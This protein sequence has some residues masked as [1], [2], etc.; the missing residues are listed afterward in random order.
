MN[1]I[2]STLKYDACI[3]CGICAAVCQ[4]ESITM[5]VTD[6]MDYEPLVGDTCI[7]CAS[8]VKYCPNAEKTRIEQNQK[9]AKDKFLYGITDCKAY[10]AWSDD[11]CAKNSAS[12]G[13]ASEIIAR[14]FDL[15]MID[16]VIHAQSIEA[17]FY[18]PHYEAVLSLTKEQALQ[19]QSR[20]SFY[21]P[22]N[23]SCVLKEVKE[24]KISRVLVVGTPCTTRGMKQLLMSRE[25]EIKECYTMALA[26]SHNVSGLFQSYIADSFGVPRNKKWRINFRDKGF[27]GIKDA[28][29]YNIAFFDEEGNV[30]ARENRFQSQW[31]DLWRNYAFS[32]KCC[33]VCS[34][35]WGADSDISI[36]DAWYKWSQDKDSKN[37]VVIRNA[38]FDGILQSCNAN[39]SL[40]SEEDLLLCQKDTIKYK[41]GVAEK[42]NKTDPKNWEQV[43]FEHIVHSWVSAK[44]KKI[45]K[46][47]GYSITIHRV[48]LLGQ[49]LICNN[50]ISLAKR[51]YGV[52]KKILMKGCKNEDSSFNTD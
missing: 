17:A 39:A 6:N 22:I 20:G 27:D 9:V 15:N 10:L 14:M 35:F 8:C 47:K 25:Y 42:R 50:P 23:F 40:I 13:M 44:S 51:T 16:G 38:K 11:N 28:S 5:R 2:D 4:N 43:D 49:W 19:P 26:C 46:K 7:Q 32:M 1:I 48:A 41:Q 36:K 29:N 33:N 12:G 45:Y 52:G 37:I 18:Q 31:T 3:G 34:D 24:R 30:I 21:A